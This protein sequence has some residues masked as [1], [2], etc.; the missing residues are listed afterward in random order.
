M[1]PVR[2][3][4]ASTSTD[5]QTPAR[6]RKGFPP[7]A[8]L[9]AFDAVA[10]LGGVRRAAQALGI[11]HSAVSR[12]LR[13]LE[14]WTGAQLVI[15]TGTSVALTEQGARYAG[16]LVGALDQ[17]S[18]ATLKLTLD[19]DD[20]RLSIWCVP[21]LAY[22]WLSPRLDLFRANHPEFDV[23]LRPSD[24]PPDFLRESADID[25][26]YFRPNARIEAAGHVQFLRLVDPIAFPVASPEYLERHEKLQT[27]VELLRHTLIHEDSADG[28]RDWL[29]DNGVVLPD[30]GGDP[31]LWHG[32]LT[33]DAAKRGQ[34]VALA[35]R[36]LAGDDIVSGRLS[37]V[38]AAGGPFRNA[39]SG[40]YVLFARRDRWRSLPVAKFRAWLTRMIDDA[41][42]TP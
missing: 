14:A 10:R 21:G 17:I 13:T 5:A 23:E 3:G 42:A 41:L 19:R 1:M 29:A 32:H 18:A 31:K 27:A 30:R 7:I 38:T 4:S 8:A 20:R 37:E 6:A 36:L 33:M 9:L 39:A 24:A 11:E 2:Q 16:Q 28:W 34:G 12:H 35:T 26:R 22:Q 15:R 25:I 40:P